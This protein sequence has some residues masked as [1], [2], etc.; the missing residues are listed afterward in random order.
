MIDNCGKLVVAY[1]QDED[2]RFVVGVFYALEMGV[3]HQKENQAGVYN[4]MAYHGC[5]SQQNLQGGSHHCGRNLCRR[6][7][8]V[9]PSQYL[10]VE[11]VVDACLL[12]RHASD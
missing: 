10:V 1:H 3:L 5:E 9:H 4:V 8:A 6:H 11:L 2:G 7:W 12:W